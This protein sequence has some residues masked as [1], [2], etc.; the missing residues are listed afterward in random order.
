M[1]IKLTP[2]RS[3]SVMNLSC[4]GETLQISINEQV[5]TFDF[6]TMQ[7]GDQAVSFVT[8]LPVNP[9]LAAYKSGGEM[10]VEMVCFYQEDSAESEKHP[11]EVILNG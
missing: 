5:D 4:A 7:E 3:D 11:R 9:I 10:I 8:S 2:Q 1:K 6:S